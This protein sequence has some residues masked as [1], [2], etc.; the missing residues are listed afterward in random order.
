MGT[1]Q[2][3]SLEPDALDSVGCVFLAATVGA[4]G[5]SGAPTPIAALLVT[6][7]LLTSGSWP[8]K[9]KAPVLLEREDRPYECYRPLH[10]VGA[11]VTGSGVVQAFLAAYHGLMPWDDWHDPEYLDSLLLPGVNRPKGVVLRTP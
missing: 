1:G 4:N 3:L 7:D 2:V 8:V 10:W 6:P 11:K 9:S 5:L